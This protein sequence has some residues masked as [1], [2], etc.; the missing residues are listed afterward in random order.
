MENNPKQKAPLG[1]PEDVPFPF[2]TE[3]EAERIVREG[4][5]KLREKIEEL[6]KKCSVGISDDPKLIIV[7]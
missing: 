2:C 5:E 1:W 6:H 3:E 4:K 7:F